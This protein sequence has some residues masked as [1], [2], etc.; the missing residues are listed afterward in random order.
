MFWKDR[1]SLYFARVTCFISV[2]FSFPVSLLWQNTKVA[3]QKT[4]CSWNHHNASYTKFW[5]SCSILWYQFSFSALGIMSR[6]EDK[7]LEEY[8]C[9]MFG[10]LSSLFL[11]ALSSVIHMWGGHHSRLELKASLFIPFFHLYLYTVKMVS[12]CSLSQKYN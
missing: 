12:V 8:F 3:L 5:L 4:H 7:C 11:V 9:K 1:I 6:A 2:M 10:I